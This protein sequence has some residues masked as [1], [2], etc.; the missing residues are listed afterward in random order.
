MWCKKI[1][2]FVTHKSVESI[3]WNFLNEAIKSRER[4]REQLI[5]IPSCVCFFVIECWLN[6]DR[7]MHEFFKLIVSSSQ[8]MMCIQ[9]FFSLLLYLPDYISI[10]QGEMK[11]NHKLIFLT[12]PLLS[13]H[14]TTS[15]H[16]QQIKFQIFFLSFL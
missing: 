2:F 9:L 7:K 12:L 8:P 3:V 6:I 15:R 1:P 11:N 14:T 10:N 16:F 4:D 13:Q 5:S